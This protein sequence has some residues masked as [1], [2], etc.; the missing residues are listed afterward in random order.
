MCVVVPRLALYSAEQHL[1]WSDRR[2][3]ET[4][5]GQLGR[6]PLSSRIGAESLLTDLGRPLRLGIPGPHQ[7]RNLTLRPGGGTFGRPTS[8][9][10]APVRCERR[11][12]PII[13]RSAGWVVCLSHHGPWRPR[14]THIWAKGPTA[15]ARADISYGHMAGLAACAGMTEMG[16]PRA[17]GTTP[18]PRPPRALS[19]IT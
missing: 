4:H 9:S 13:A 18:H 15:A 5:D 17:D 3:H 11:V 2:A 8:A 12:G 1:S 19:C 14:R 16:S 7:G 6:R 10:S